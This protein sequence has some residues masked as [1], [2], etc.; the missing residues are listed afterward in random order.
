MRGTSESLKLDS[1]EGWERY[2]THPR[3]PSDQRNS[4]DEKSIMLKSVK[5][6]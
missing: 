4:N 2:D 1:G 3:N 5:T 6:F